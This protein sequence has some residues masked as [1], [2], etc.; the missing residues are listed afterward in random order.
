M[1]GGV[2]QRKRDEE[3][4]TTPEAQPDQLRSSKVREG[5]HDL[6][7]ASPERGVEGA[8]LENRRQ[9]PWGKTSTEE[10]GDPGGLDGTTEPRRW[11]P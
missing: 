7:P 11:P 2:E 4:S 10:E 9:D 1:A 5:K 8:G 6:L 3:V